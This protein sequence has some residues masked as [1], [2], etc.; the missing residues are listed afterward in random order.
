MTVELK[1]RGGREILPGKRDLEGGRR[2]SKRK[3]GEVE[4]CLLWGR[5]GPETGKASKDKFSK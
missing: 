1:P 5:R 4:D 3:K 2:T